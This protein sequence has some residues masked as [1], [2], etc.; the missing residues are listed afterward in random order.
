MVKCIFSLGIVDKKIIL[1]FLMSINQVILNLI[2]FFYERKKVET[3]NVL[4]SL[5]ISL[6]EMSLMIIPYILKYKNPILKKNIC[7][8][9]NIKYQ[10]ILF[11][12]DI[13][14]IL[15][16]GA[17]SFLG[18]ST[19]EVS[20]P[21][22]SV[23]CTK[24]TLEMIILIIL[25]I[26][27][28]NYKYYIHHIICILAFCICSVIIDILL[29][30]YN[31]GV[32]NQ[33]IGKNILE[34]FAIVAEMVN[35]CYQMHMMVNLSYNYWTV[36]FSLGLFL[37]I[38]NIFMLTGSLILG[39]PNGDKEKFVNG[40]YHYCK[41]VAIGYIILRFLLQ[42]IFFG[43]VMTLLK[44]LTLSNFSVTYILI[45]YEISKFSVVLLKETNKNKWYSFIFFFCQFFSLMFFLEIFEFN[46]CKL[47]EN[48]KRNILKREETDMVMRESINSTEIQGYILKDIN[49]ERSVSRI[50][51]MREM[52]ENNEKEF[53]ADNSN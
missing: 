48:T 42:F 37:F 38:L 28:M 10:A 30:N 46:F 15:L 41:N 14:L 7:N 23:L 5:A 53:T 26:L 33:T 49:D 2:D 8:K 22:L 12:A 6:G 25:T 34:V 32:L 35:Y 45:S 52:E 36:G 47:N 19:E 3:S 11:G 4:D 13:L 21:H 18:N 24:E 20:N 17:S 39:D 31:E 27:F 16:I 44:M 50:D 1:P 51:T 9:K 29:N 43:F 40:L